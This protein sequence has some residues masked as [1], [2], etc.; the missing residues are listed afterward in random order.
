MVDQVGK[1]DEIIILEYWVKSIYRSSIQKIDACQL[2]LALNNNQ[3]LNNNL[4]S[5]STSVQCTDVAHQWTE[6]IT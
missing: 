5:W 3:T 6:G 4:F 1:I 2:L